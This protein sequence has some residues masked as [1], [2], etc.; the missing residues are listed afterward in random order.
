MILPLS[1]ITIRRQMSSMSPRSWVVEHDRGA[2]LLDQASDELA[3]AVLDR[4]VQAD[5]GLVEVEQLG[6][7]EQGHAQVGPHPLAERD[8][9]GRNVHEFGQAQ[10]LGELGRGSAL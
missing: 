3:D 8:L 1:M 5:R 10:D 7:V 2:A 6:V 9:A 4:D